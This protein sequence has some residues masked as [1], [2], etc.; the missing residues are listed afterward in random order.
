MTQTNPQNNLELMRTLHDSWNAQ[1]WERT[2]STLRG[3]LATACMLCLFTLLESPA[4]AQVPD[5]DWLTY[6]RHP[7]WRSVLAS[8][9]GQPFQRRPIEGDLHLYAARGVLAS[10]RSACY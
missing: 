10:D 1:D 3:I 2:M 6:N 5:G 7:G 4:G 9:G 8:Q